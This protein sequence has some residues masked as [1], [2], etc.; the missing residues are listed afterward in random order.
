MGMVGM[1]ELQIALRNSGQTMGM[2]NRLGGPAETLSSSWVLDQGPQR[3][4]EEDW[5]TWGNE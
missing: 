5:I 1:H 3:I 4:A 2:A